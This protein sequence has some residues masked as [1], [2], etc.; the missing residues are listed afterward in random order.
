[1][2]RLALLHTSPVHI[3]VFDALRD[4]DHPALELR[5]FVSEELLERARS[6][7]PEAVA[8]EVRA[9]LDRAVADGAVAV[10]CTCSTIGAVAEAARPGVPVLRVDRPMAAAAVA[11]GPRVVVLATVESTLGPTVAL[12]EEEAARA[13]SP[14]TVRTLLAADAWDHFKAGDMDAY[15]RAVASAADKVTD[16]DAIVLAQASMTPAQH[17]TTT[18]VPVLS[19]PRPGLAAGAVAAAGA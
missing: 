12:V 15:A 9:M 8:G 10:L 13:G 14:T 3:P 11:A 1:M 18:A 16:A 7:G 5:H 4:E 2:S 6:E 19:S 17:L